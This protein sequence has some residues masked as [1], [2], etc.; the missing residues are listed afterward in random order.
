VEYFA[1]IRA[2]NVGDT[3][4]A[5]W[6][7]TSNP[8]LLDM[9]GIFDG[10]S[11]KSLSVN[12]LL[13]YEATFACGTRTEMH[14]LERNFGSLT[15]SF[16]DCVK[17]GKDT[18]K[19]LRDASPEQPFLKD[20]VVIRVTMKSMETCHME[21]SSSMPQEEQVNPVYKNFAKVTKCKGLVN[22]DLAADLV[23]A[24][25]DATFRGM[26][27]GSGMPEET[28]VELLVDP[29]DFMQEVSL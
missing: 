9:A 13:G 11:D 23:G 7:M 28:L 2:A 14:A 29:E 20:E 1:H 22:S 27:Q 10:H 18:N 21:M 15:G 3:F 25:G 4:Q 5:G 19:A 16:R 17:K 26:I 6:S 24:K 12:D 8:Y